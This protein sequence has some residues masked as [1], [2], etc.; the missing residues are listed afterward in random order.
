VESLWWIE[1]EDV[2]WGKMGGSSEMELVGVDEEDKISVEL[3]CWDE[4]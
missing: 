1:V 3:D 2:C 4:I